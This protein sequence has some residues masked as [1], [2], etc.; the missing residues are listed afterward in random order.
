MAGGSPQHLTLTP[1][2]VATVTMTADFRAVEIVNVDGL[3]TVYVRKDGVDPVV[4][5]EGTWVLP[6]TIGSME[7]GMPAGAP[8]VVKLISTGAAQV[9]VGGSR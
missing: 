8:T 2:T 3:Y 6:A 1:N 7:L 9:A 4:A 5:A